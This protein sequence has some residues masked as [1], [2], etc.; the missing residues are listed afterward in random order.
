ML[1][2]DNNS[3]CASGGSGGD[4]KQQSSW[5]QQL[6]CKGHPGLAQGWYIFFCN[7]RGA[8]LPAVPVGFLG[9]VF[10]LLGFFGIFLSQWRT[11]MLKSTREGS[12]RSSIRAILVLFLILSC[13]FFI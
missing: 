12:N 13:S 1:S 11:A 9:V 3:S 4:G 7:V 5:K 8:L 10:L 6:R 2:T